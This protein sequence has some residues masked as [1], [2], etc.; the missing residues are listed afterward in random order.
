MS[1]GR[2]FPIWLWLKIKPEGQT[3][4]FGPCFHLPRQAMLEFRFFEPPPYS[5][6][7]VSPPSKA[8]QA[9]AINQSLSTLGL[10]INR[11]V[12]SL[13]PKIER[14]LRRSCWPP[15]GLR[16]FCLFPGS[17]GVSPGFGLQEVAGFVSCQWVKS[18]GG[19]NPGASESA[20][21]EKRVGFMTR[22]YL[23]FLGGVMSNHV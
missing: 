5:P 11:L 16:C 2:L 18:Q 8:A 22:I 13:G 14:K 15:G 4:G 12:K 17:M 1:L 3:A 9:K 7:V 6:P 10:V 20:P 21:Y 19:L 23:F